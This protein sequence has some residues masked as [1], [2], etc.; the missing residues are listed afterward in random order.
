M[1]LT[2]RCFGDHEHT[3][4]PGGL[5]NTTCE[6]VG[7]CYIKITTVSDEHYELRMGCL[8]ADSTWQCHERLN[9][10]SEFSS[11]DNIHYECCD[12]KLAGSMCNDPEVNEQ[13][14]LII[15]EFAPPAQ[16]KL[17]IIVSLCVVITCT[18]S[19]VLYIVYR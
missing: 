7:D 13:L 5:I 6:A 2:C 1:S 12:P 18:F 17:A 4:C 15:P 14:K 3:H 10:T 11:V 19:V 9:Y 16:P 8:P